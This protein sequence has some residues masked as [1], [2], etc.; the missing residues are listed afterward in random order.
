MSTGVSGLDEVV[1]GGY[2]PYFDV[3]PRRYR[4]RIL[5]ASMSRFIK[6]ALVVNRAAFAR[7]TQ[8]VVLEEFEIAHDRL[9]FVE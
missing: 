4:F 2:F 5:I 7:G 6:L 9:S 8:V 3:L 1:N